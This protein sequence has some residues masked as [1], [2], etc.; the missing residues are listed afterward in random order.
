MNLKN[1]DKM[2]TILLETIIKLMEKALPK[3]VHSFIGRNTAS[4][5]HLIQD[6]IVRMWHNHDG[7]DITLSLIHI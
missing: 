2:A 4:K 5:L 7:D 3:Q 1:G 6:S